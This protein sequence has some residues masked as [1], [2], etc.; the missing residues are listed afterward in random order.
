[1]LTDKPVDSYTILIYGKAE[2][3][4]GISVSGDDVT[5]LV[6]GTI[7]KVEEVD[8]ED[9]TKERVY[10]IKQITAE[11]CPQKNQ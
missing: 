8:N 9:G 10:K 5:L 3:P 4:E 1:M 7:K 2:L 6:K 11:I